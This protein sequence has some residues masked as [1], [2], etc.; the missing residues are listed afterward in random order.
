MRTT[1]VRRADILVVVLASLAFATSA[2]LAKLAVGL[3]PVI[4]ASGRTAIAAC[5][6]VLAAPSR[7]L[8]IYRSL[9]LRAWLGLLGAGACLGAHFA[10]FLGGL[11]QTSFAATVALISLEPLA[12]V[13]AAWLAFGLAPRRAEWLGIVLAMAGAFVVS[14]GAGQGEHRLSGDLMVV[15]AVALYG[16]YVAAARGLRDSMP[17]TPYAAA[18]YGIASVVLV[19]FFWAEKSGTV[20]PSAWVALVLLAVI[21]TLVG[22]T[23]V[24]VAARTLAPSVVALTSPG[25]TVGSLLIGAALLHKWPTRV[26]GAGAAL[27]LLGA[28]TAIV[29][30]ARG[31]AIG[32]GE[33]VSTG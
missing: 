6:L 23:L 1:A 17:A 25:E 19:P 20:P 13:V 10:L 2:P 26:E 8:A 18:V 12:V 16:V 30:A 21:P 27:I 5:L 22:H 7:T 9:P 32:R 33:V 4:V 11:A 3:P 28:V 29:G 14:R 24:Q 31:T 15:A